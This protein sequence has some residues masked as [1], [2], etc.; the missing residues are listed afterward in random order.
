MYLSMPEFN[1]L[2]DSCQVFTKWDE[3]W[4]K[5]LTILRDI[6]KKKPVKMGGWKVTFVHKKLQTRL[7]EIRE[8]RKQVPFLSTRN[9][10]STKSCAR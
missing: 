8:F 3:D 9:V 2:M 5:F 6:N 1:T 10:F 4:E 7:D